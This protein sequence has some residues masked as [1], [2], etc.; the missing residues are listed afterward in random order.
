[1][2]KYKWYAV[3]KYDNTKYLRINDGD[4]E[5]GMC[6][7]EAYVGSEPT[8]FRT[9]EACRKWT[10]DWFRGSFIIKKKEV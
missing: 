10:R 4:A 1:M 9:K 2:N 3:W 8:Y 6:E 5:N 7:P